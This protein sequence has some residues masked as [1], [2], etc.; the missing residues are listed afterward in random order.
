MHIDL[1]TLGLQACNL[2]VLLALL[3]WLFY[4]PVLAVIEARRQALQQ[5]REQARRR[6]SRPMPK[7]PS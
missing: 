6:C 5:Q 3:R 2:L 7:R 1:W 4:R